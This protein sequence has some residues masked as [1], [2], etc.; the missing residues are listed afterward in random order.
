M[1]SQVAYLRVFLNDPLSCWQHHPQFIQKKE[2]K[3]HPQLM[4]ALTPGPGANWQPF[5]LGMDP[6]NLIFYFTKSSVISYH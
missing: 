6:L 3:N 2:K 1:V 4:M 5:Q